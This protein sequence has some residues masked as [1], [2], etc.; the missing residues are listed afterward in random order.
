[1]ARP[2]KTGLGYF[3]HDV[4]ASS[5]EKVEALTALHGNDGYA[6]YFRLL[7]F[8]YRSE[9][10]ELDLSDERV[11]LILPRRLHVSRRRFEMILADA[12]SLGLFD[13]LKFSELK[14]LT[15]SGIR[16][17]FLEVTKMRKR[18]RDSKL[19]DLER[20]STE[21]TPQGKPHKENPTKK[22]KIKKS[23]AEREEH[24]LPENVEIAKTFFTDKGFLHPDVEAPKFFN[25]FSARNWEGVRDWRALAALWNERTRGRDGN[26][27]ATVT[28]SSRPRVSQALGDEKWKEQLIGCS[29][30]GQVHPA[31]QVCPENPQD[32]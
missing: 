1:M 27:R 4:D 24:S 7:E 18:W 28:G 32:A 29:A 9:N 16:K 8:I 2:L 12:C 10:G 15:S 20:F 17:R 14:L 26:G 25:Y 23:K 13:K 3:P 21:K 5:D 30:C 6:V 11:R 22:S 19:N 31:G